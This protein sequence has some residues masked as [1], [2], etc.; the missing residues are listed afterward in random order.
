MKS[1]VILTF[2][3]SLVNEPVTYN[4]VKQFDLQINILKANIS[5]GETG[6]LLLELSGE[7]KQMELARNYLSKTGVEVEA[8]EK[9]ICFQKEACIHCGACTAVCFTGALQLNIFERNLV[10][11]PEKCVVCGLCTTACPLQL[12]KMAWGYAAN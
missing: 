3:A 9:A 10:F 12:F 6:T 1:R 2:S 7:E 4:L 8:V 5:S 11:K